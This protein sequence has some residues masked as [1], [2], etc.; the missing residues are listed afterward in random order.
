LL[1]DTGLLFECVGDFER[2]R[3]VYSQLTRSLQLDGAAERLASLENDIMV[4]NAMVRLCLVDLRRGQVEETQR[5]LQLLVDACPRFRL[6]WLA[7]AKTYL[8]MHQIPAA[9]SA[10]QRCLELDAESAQDPL[11]WTGIGILYQL[12]G[13]LEEAWE[14]YRVAQRLV[15]V[16]YEFRDV[17]LFYLATLKCASREFDPAIMLF[18]H[19]LQ[20]RAEERSAFL[21][22]GQKGR[23]VS[24]ASDAEAAGLIRG[25]DEHPQ[26][27]VFD[28]RAT[29]FTTET[30]SMQEQNQSLN[31]GHSSGQTGD[32]A[33]QR[34]VLGMVHK[35]YATY[36]HQRRFRARRAGL[37]LI[38][39]EDLSA[40][41]DARTWC[42]IGHIYL[43]CQN[44]LEARKAFENALISEPADVDALQQLSWALILLNEVTHALDHLRRCVQLDPTRAHSW[45]LLGR[46]Y[47]LTEQ[48]MEACDAY[49]QAVLRDPNHASYWCSIGVLYYQSQ[50]YA[51]AADAYM[52]AIR[53]NP[54]LAEVWFDLG[55]LYETYGQIADACSA[56]HRAMSLNPTNSTYQERLRAVSAILQTGEGISGTM[57]NTS[58]GPVSA[59]RLPPAPPPHTYME[60]M[61]PQHRVSG[62][63]P[64]NHGFNLNRNSVTRPMDR[65]GNTLLERRMDDERS[66]LPPG[67]NVMSLAPNAGGMRMGGFPQLQSGEWVTNSNAMGMTTHDLEGHRASGLP[68]MVRKMPSSPSNEK[69]GMGGASAL[70]RHQKA[71]ISGPE[72][73]SS[74]APT[75]EHSTRALLPLVPQIDPAETGFDHAEPVAEERPASNPAIQVPTGRGAFAG[76]N[77]QD[78]HRPKIS[79]EPCPLENTVERN[80]RLIILPGNRNRSSPTQAPTPQARSSRVS[81][82]AQKPHAADTLLRQRRATPDSTDTEQTDGD[83][84]A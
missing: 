21:L 3:V 38:L 39:D 31:G 60:Q 10:Y 79:L 2:A 33:A 63:M 50:Q 59:T 77:A 35:D 16:N 47:A 27:G 26:S 4:Q 6:G 22:T 71:V 68:S 56:Y 66:S 82:A 49:Q 62:A 7:L 9:F 12:Y 70:N 69:E 25:V 48:Y 44:V 83:S 64:T 67:S 18:R 52:R 19:A 42:E 73:S 57:P 5:R 40:L 65:V 54:G 41:S 37:D 55:I 32:M 76:Q 24:G 53:L 72:A 17:I 80:K 29:S 15:P 11:V 84:S 78:S 1:L 51:D 75:I 36:E 30:V 61:A 43:L 45:Y 81:D 74:A 23:N 20:Y 46:A 8:L 13:Q 28:R 58:S 34:M 14:A